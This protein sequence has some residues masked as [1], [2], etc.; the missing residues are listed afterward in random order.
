MCNNSNR[1]KTLKIDIEKQLEV[2]KPEKQK[3]VLGA[4]APIV[5]ELNNLGLE[6]PGIQEMEQTPERSARAK[7]FR[8]DFKKA[9]KKAEDKKSELKEESLQEGKA[10]QGVFNKIKELTAGTLEEVICIEQYY[11]NLEKA[12][13][14]KLRKER[15]LE[16][17]KYE[18]DGSG[19]PLGEME[20]AIWE[21]FLFGAKSKYEDNIREEQEEAERIERQLK[22]D[23]LSNERKDLLKGRWAFLSSEYNNISFGEMTENKFGKILEETLNKK[24]AYEEEQEQ[25]RNDNEKLKIENDKAEA[26]RL[27][28]KKASDK[29]IKD[30]RE[31]REKLEAEIKE[32]KRL[33][34]LAEQEAQNA[35]D[36]EKLSSLIKD[37]STTGISMKNQLAT[38]MLAEIVYQIQSF[39]DVM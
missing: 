32:N 4:F 18:V 30:E 14:E 13:K 25:V 38:K 28:L 27:R 2:L 6:Y 5:Q 24:I 8:I 17:E 20:S 15:L 11:E 34:D 35:P 26:K 19:L 23:I 12:E 36:K 9:V 1:R 3:L 16:L 21:N 31:K 29:K 33:K 10:I 39:I 37:I 22:I 7:R